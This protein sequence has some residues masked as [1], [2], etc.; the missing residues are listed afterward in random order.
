MIDAYERMGKVEVS[1]VST[2]TVLDVASAY[3]L[4]EKLKQAI[5]D[6]ENSEQF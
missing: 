4:I 6:C 1:V 2:Q 5:R 3:V